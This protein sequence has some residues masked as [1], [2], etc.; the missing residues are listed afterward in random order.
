MPSFDVVSEINAHELANAVDQANRELSQRFDFRDAN[1]TYE[2]DVKEFSVALKA[3]NE[4]QVKQMVDILRLKVAKRGIEV[5][6][7]EPKDMEKNV[8]EARQKILFRHGIDADTGRRIAK[9]VKDAKLKVQAGI[10]GDKVRVT[11]KSR[12]ELQATIAMLRRENF[13]RPLQ[14]ENFRD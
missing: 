5:G 2:L 11:G 8:A 9:L 1:A 3:K 13:D 12:D 6:C 7:M 14:Y 4:Y 10:H